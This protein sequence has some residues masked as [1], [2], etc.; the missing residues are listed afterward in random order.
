MVSGGDK[1]T[2]RFPFASCYELQHLL[3]QSWCWVPRDRA[4]WAE[5]KDLPNSLEVDH[6]SAGTPCTPAGY[7]VMPNGQVVMRRRE[8]RVWVRVRWHPNCQEMY[9]CPW[10]DVDHQQPWTRASPRGMV[11]ERKVSTCF[12]SLAVL[13]GEVSVKT[14][15]SLLFWSS[16]LDGYCSDPLQRST[17]RQCLL[18]GQAPNQTSGPK[19][20]AVPRGQDLCV[21]VSS[22]YRDL[23][24][25]VR[26]KWEDPGRALKGGRM[27]SK[28]SINVS[29]C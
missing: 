22:W 19:W 6:C 2:H 12:A 23:N 24:H 28:H 14:P 29:C 21:L 4:G 9:R 3:I 27:H 10:P 25:V 20:K 5:M 17:Q 13:A 18:A 15:L 11:L 26:I 7:W 16:L 8:Q 1:V